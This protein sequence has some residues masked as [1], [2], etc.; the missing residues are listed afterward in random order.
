MSWYKIT[1]ENELDS[2]SLVIYK[3]RVRENIKKMIEIAGS[4]E[5]LFTHVKTNKM[6]EIVKMMLEEGITKFK[7]ATIAEAEITAMAGA[8][9]VLISHQLVGP[10]IERLIQLSKLYPDVTFAS[11]IDNLDTAKEHNQAFGA[12]GMISHVFIDVNSGMD[13]SGH[14]LDENIMDLYRYLSS[15]ADIKLYGLHVYDG[16]IRSDDF[17]SRKNEIDTG[18]VDVKHFLE[19]IEAAGF[20]KPM[21]IAGG[22]PAF[23]SHALREETYCSPGTCVLWDWGYGDRLTEQPFEYA[24][25]VLTRIISKPQKGIVT[26]DM[27]HKAVSAE[28]PIDKRIRFLNLEDY[29]LMGQSEEHGVI[30]VKD[31][32]ALKVGDVLYGVPFHVCPTV[33]LYD[34]AYVVENQRVDQVW[35][36]LGRRRKISV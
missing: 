4:A 1:N 25:L 14:P 15:Q 30:K 16:H 2:P 36:V 22:T 19:A 34:E 29:E 28:N 7:C 5:R 35:Q 10:K 3:E 26:V 13:R 23:T 6:P 12:N 18:F 20:P 8:K 31:W 24:A 27:G 17:E 11:L 32:D 9:F 21:V 33:N